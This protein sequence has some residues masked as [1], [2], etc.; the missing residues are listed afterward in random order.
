[1]ALSLWW[2]LSRLSPV[3]A[4][5]VG[6]AFARTIGPLTSRRQC[7]LDNLRL[8]FPERDAS[9]RRALAREIWTNAG[10]VLGEYPHI[11]R[12]AESGLEIEDGCGLADF[13][14]GRRQGI[15]VGAHLANWEIAALALARAHVPVLAIQAGVENPYIAPLLRRARLRLRCPTV[16]R[17]ASMRPLYRHLRAGGSLAILA[18]GKVAGGALIPLFGHDARTSTAP[19]RLALHFGV[20]IV[21]V[22]VERLGPARLICR[23]AKPIQ[24]PEDAGE[25]WILEIGLRLN[26][27]FE[28][29]IAAAPGQWLC[30]SRRWDES[31]YAQDGWGAKQQTKNGPYGR[32]GETGRRSSLQS[33][34]RWRRLIRPIR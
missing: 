23:I 8:A 24:V 11:E 2:G 1:M 3:T 15:F 16:A 18:D 13:A 31:L 34:P 17:N 22:R 10:N 27:L 19:G 9:A 7:V 28:Q 32:A 12:I 4:A 33:A 5:S 6:A 26:R 25:E 14:S 30:T 29:W 21:P 20:D